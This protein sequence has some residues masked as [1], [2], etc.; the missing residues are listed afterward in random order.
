MHGFDGDAGVA[1]Q[2]GAV[3]AA[4]APEGIVDHLDAGFGDGLEVDQFGDALEE[5]GLDV[6]G[7]EFLGDAG[8]G[9]RLRSSAILSMAAS[10][11]LVDFGQGGRA[12]GSG[13]LDAVVLGRIVRGGE[14]DGAGGFEG[15]HGIGDGGRGRGLG[16]DDGRDA[17]AASTRAASATKLSP[18]KRGSRPTSTRC[19][20]GWVLT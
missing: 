17:A 16:D 19:G 14:V 3:A 10:I 11:C 12:V 7:F 4:R 8:L 1:E 13:V 15:A 20:A 2:I 6:D 18:R 5:G 9:S